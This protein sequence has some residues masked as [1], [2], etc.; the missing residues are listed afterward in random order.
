M[1]K[2]YGYSDSTPKVRDFAGASLA[3][4]SYRRDKEAP[5]PLSIP[6]LEFWVSTRFPSSLLQIAGDV[7][8]KATGDPIGYWQD[9]STNGRNLTQT[10]GSL[11]PTIKL[12][13]INGQ[14]SV[15]VDNTDD[16]LDSPTIPRTI[17]GTQIE[18]TKYG[19]NVFKATAGDSGNTTFYINSFLGQSELLDKLFYS[20]NLT[21]LQIDQLVAYFKPVVPYSS[22][23]SL[24]TL[25]QYWK[26]RV[27]FLTFP[28]IDTKQVTNL[29]QTWFN[30][31]KMTSFPL[32]NTSN[33][34]NF[35]SKIGRAHV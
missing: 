15:I 25:A 35:S 9:Q 1:K 13:A 27:D 10:T 21:Q 6:G 4:S 22:Y 18:V 23:S 8:S 11:K 26:N 24:T 34:T 31:N 32:I 30:C 33:V 17:T 7:S 12:Q 16:R 28:F 14:N 20:T 2:L 3:R 19:I 29:Y 5:L